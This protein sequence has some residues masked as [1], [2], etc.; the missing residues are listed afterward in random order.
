MKYINNFFVLGTYCKWHFSV[1]Y[2]MSL[3]HL[4]VLITFIHLYALHS[5]ENIFYCQVTVIGPS[6]SGM[7]WVVSCRQ[8]C[9]KWAQYVARGETMVCFILIYWIQCWRSATTYIH[10]FTNGIYIH[11]LGWEICKLQTQCS[12]SAA[13]PQLRQWQVLKQRY[14]SLC[15]WKDACCKW[16]FAC[17][18]TI[19]RCY[20]I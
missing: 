17:M 14:C 18:S 4:W 12:A 5:P 13:Q 7:R 15:S 20:S 2:N 6:R 10:T 8:R 3:T 1:E 11:S 9:Q 19:A 16:S